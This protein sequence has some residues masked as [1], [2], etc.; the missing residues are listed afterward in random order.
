M[1]IILATRIARVP[2]QRALENADGIEL[3]V[4]ED[5]SE[6][7]A[8]AATADALVLSDPRGPDGR[9]IAE[10][11]KTPGSRVRWVQIL[12]AGADGLLAHGVPAQVIVTNQG[13]AV[14]P[15][16][17]EH[18]MA[19]IL[20][21]AR[22]IPAI[23]EQSARHVWNKEFTRPPFSVEGKVLTIVGLG[24]IGRQLAQRA[25]GFGMELIGV[26]RSLASDP[27]VDRVLPLTDLHNALGQADIVALCVASSAETRHL[28][29]DD[30][31]NAMK[32][33][34]LFINLTRG[35]TVD[36]IALQA[37][38]SSG[39]LA[40]AFIDVT[41]PEPLP[42]DDPLWNAP[43]LIISPHIAGVGSTRTG[44]RVANVVIENLRR[45][46]AGEPLIHRLG[47]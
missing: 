17:A 41:D 27:A 12:S 38:L 13:G 42:A 25:A 28:M 34:T 5:L 32:P 11:L 15:A 8:K 14:A 1:R 46:Q 3:I 20:G 44:G 40:G 10:A 23:A 29:N 26:S 19:M 36:Q 22:Q 18:G 6:V 43:N 33:G 39:H 30:A 45:F 2:V 31:F 4:C 35:E 24:N 16:V 9:A 37:A 7:A 21:M 47:G